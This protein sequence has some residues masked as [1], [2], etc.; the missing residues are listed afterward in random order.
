MDH[1]TLPC[2]PI[3]G[4]LR[5]PFLGFNPAYQPPFKK[6]RSHSKLT[7]DEYY[8]FNFDKS[9]RSLHDIDSLQQSWLFFGL[10]EETIGALLKRYRT[11]DSLQLLVDTSTPGN[12]V[13]STCCLREDFHEIHQSLHDFDA[14]EKEVHKQRAAE[15][16]NVTYGIL[17]TKL[18]QTRRLAFKPS[19]AAHPGAEQSPITLS[20]LC[21][22]TYL[23]SLFGVHDATRRNRFEYLEQGLLEARMLR[24]GWCPSQVKRLSRALLPPSLYLVANMRRPDPHIDHALTDAAAGRQSC[25]GYQCFANQV[26]LEDYKT[27]HDAACKVDA[28]GATCGFLAADHRQM[29]EWL[30]KGTLPLAL[31]T[32]DPPKLRMYSS[33]AR[34]RYVAISH[35]WAQGLG[36]QNANAL[37]R[38]QLRRLSAM[39][40]ELYPSSQRPVP[41]WIDTLSCPTE[42]E[43]A[44]SLA[45]VQMR[46][47]YAGADK[48]LVID[49]YVNMDTARMSD[50]EMLLR[51]FCSGWTTRLWTLQEGALDRDLYF[52]VRDINLNLAAVRARVRADP[53]GAGLDV[54]EVLEELGLGWFSLNAQP[55]TVGQRLI[56]IARAVRHRAT[57]VAEDEALCLGTLAGIDMELLADPKVPPQERMRVFWEQFEAPPS[58]LVFWEGENLDQIGYRWAPKSFLGLA[59]AQ[60][61]GVQWSGFYERMEREQTKLIKGSGLEIQAAGLLMGVQDG[62]IGDVFWVRIEEGIWLHV[63]CCGDMGFL[64]RDERRIYMYRGEDTDGSAGTKVDT[65]LAI[66]LQDEMD[67]SML[68]G[69][70]GRTTAQGLL[71]VVQRPL[72][73]VLRAKPLTDVFVVGANW[74]LWDDEGFTWLREMAA[75]LDLSVRPDGNEGNVAWEDPFSKEGVVE[76]RNIDG[77]EWWELD[78]QTI[79]QG[80]RWTYGYDGQ[81]YVFQGL[82]LTCDQAWLIT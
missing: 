35:V 53:Q 80:D 55:S 29:F 8:R 4:P 45:I 79:K 62:M 36:N 31:Y 81:H 63:T 76:C 69:N 40:N 37:P 58:M 6:F 47:T 11:P 32:D 16:V 72:A 65:C 82:S 30:K 23:S 21:L 13:I 24:D 60:V 5:I 26:R 71:A 14:E 52:R 38:C 18:D 61:P 28:S 46:N 42:P 10:I 64:R 78:D 49:S 41:F 51:I 54:E 27:K 68:D 57:S 67:A 70:D 73:G 7:D 34:T 48:V 17:R 43:E 12:P 2:N 44:T 59:G 39:V 75:K 15:L 56:I 1:C 22:C 3:H 66:V 77:S 25:T 74:T 50:A 19:T 33:A 9:E 20:I